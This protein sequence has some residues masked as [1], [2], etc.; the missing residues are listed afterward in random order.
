MTTTRSPPVTVR[1]AP[2]FAVQRQLRPIVWTIVHDLFLQNN[3]LPKPTSVV[4]VDI[5]G[6][7]HVTLTVD[8]VARVDAWAEVMD[9]DV[10]S[11]ILPDGT[12]YDEANGTIAVSD[13]GGRYADEP[14]EVH[15]QCSTVEHAPRPVAVVQ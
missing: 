12:W 6:Q 13:S 9:V 10:D 14:V 2:L 4:V 1:P 5:E 15:V 8:T 7:L 3:D 11:E